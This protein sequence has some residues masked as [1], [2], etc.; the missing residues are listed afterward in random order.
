MLC[1]C[2]TWMRAGLEREVV[3]WNPYTCKPVI[4]L[5]GH[6]AG[7]TQLE[8]NAE[9]EQVISLSIDRVVKVWDLRNNEC[10]QSV[11]DD[12]I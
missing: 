1:I 10:T 2:Y 9:F 4:S 7:I 5:E 6:Q 8:V 11:S 12:E 3:V